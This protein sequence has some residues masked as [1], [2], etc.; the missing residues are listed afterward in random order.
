VANIAAREAWE[1]VAF[2]V[3]R[4]QVGPRVPVHELLPVLAL[5]EHEFAELCEDSLFKRRVKEYAKELTETGESFAMKARLQA[6]DLLKTNYRIAQDRDTPP[7]VA[8]AAIAATVRWAGLE[9]KPG[10]DAA[11]QDD[12]KR[13]RISINI[14]LGAATTK[15]VKE[16]TEGITVEQAADGD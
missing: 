8:I 11:E 2:E 10:G 7:S 1:E 14:N 6:E 4:N 13:P 9:K 15:Q 12:S 5:T 3:A 16:L